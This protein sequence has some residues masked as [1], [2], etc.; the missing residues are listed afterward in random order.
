MNERE[1]SWWTNPSLM[2]HSEFATRD[3]MRHGILGESPLESP[4]S[5]NSDRFQSVDLQRINVSFTTKSTS[6]TLDSTDASTSQLI[7]R[8]TEESSP[9]R[10]RGA[11]LLKMC[12]VHSH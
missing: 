8:D 11:G 3:F 4:E 9:S 12:R 6:A 7:T 2:S 5:R 1:S 10:L